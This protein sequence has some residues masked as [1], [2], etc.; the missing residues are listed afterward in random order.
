MLR[1]GTVVQPFLAFY[2][3]D[4]RG[5]ST[6]TTGLVLAVIGVG[7][8]LSQLVGG[9]LAD[10]IGR[11]STLTASVLATGAV[12]VGLGYAQTTATI[13]AMAFTL[14]LTLDMYRPASQAIIADVVP[15]EARAR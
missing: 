10:R 13:V 15:A 8:V 4:S 3:T 14:G 7:G 2:L 1:L 9:A 12:M 11:R 5:M 6:T